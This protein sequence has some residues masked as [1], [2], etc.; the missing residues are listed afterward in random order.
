MESVVLC[1]APADE[2]LARY[3]AKAIES[4]LPVAAVCGEAVI[5]RELDLI[6]A[7]ERALSA[8]AA[9]VL[10]SPSSVP[11]I[12]DRKVWEPVFFGQPKPLLGFVLVSD[13]KFPALLRREVFFD[14]TRDVAA[15]ARDIKRWLLRPHQLL[16]PSAPVIEEL[17]ALLEGP[18][19]A[20][21][22]EPE[23]AVQFAN[24]CADDFE[25]VYRFDCKGRSRAGVIGDIGSALGLQ[26]RAAITEWFAGHRVL[27]L[28]AGVREEDRDFATPGG[29]GS[30]IFTAPGDLPGCAP[31]RVGDAVRSFQETLLLLDGW[32]AVGMLKAQERREEVLEVL[33]Q[34]AS[35]AQQ[36]GDAGALA[37]IERELFWIGD[38]GVADVLIPLTEGEQLRLRF[39]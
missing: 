13:C 21:G 4:N 31:N 36:T 37:R 28:I 26:N 35:A 39:E 2:R 14:A 17:R 3:L 16:R 25:A 1:Y 10:L 23:I 22:I 38:S 29:L 20:S 5:G 7:T 32:L 15:I 6:E 24:E 9:V 12:W 30:V 34:M 8:D 33:G 18:G 27:L 19:S 11:K